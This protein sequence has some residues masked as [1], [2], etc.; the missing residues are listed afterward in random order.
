M[1]RNVF[2]RFGILTLFSYIFF[3][4]PSLAI[5]QK[6]TT[7]QPNPKIAP[8]KPK[9]KKS[10]KTIKFIAPTII[11]TEME[12]EHPPVEEILERGSPDVGMIAS[13]DEYGKGYQGNINGITYTDFVN[14]M[15]G[16]GGHGHT[17]P[18][19]VW[20]FGMVQ[21]SPDTRT[22][23]SWDGCGG[24]YYDDT[25]IYG[26]SHT[27]LSGTGVSD[28]GDVLFQPKVGNSTFNPLKYR[29][30][31]SH[32][33]EYARPG[34]YSNSLLDHNV[35]V[36]LTAHQRV[37]AHKYTFKKSTNQ[38][39]DS[40]FVII[41]LKHRDYLLGHQLDVETGGNVVKGYRRSK[42]WAN[43]QSV[44]F[45]SYF[46]QKILSVQYNENKS[47]AILY[48]GQLNDSTKR[49]LVLEAYVGISFTSLQGAELNLRTK[50]IGK[51]SNGVNYIKFPFHSIK[52]EVE[53]AWNKELGQINVVNAHS[54][55]GNKREDFRKF[56]TALYHCMIHP[57]LASDED[58]K[59]R[60]RDQQ[61]HQGTRPYYSVFS[62]WDTYRAL[63][64]L[65]TI[66]DRKR[67]SDFINTFL[68]Q[69]VQGGRLPVW[70]LGSCETDCMIGY[71]SVSVIADAL[72]KG[73]EN[74]DVDLALE[75]MI[76]SSN[77]KEDSYFMKVN[78]QGKLEKSM[79]KND[80]IDVKSESESVSKSLEYAYNDWCI[81][82][83]I[84]KYKL[85]QKIDLAKWNDVYNEMMRRSNR[86]QHY[87]DPKTKYMRP[88][89]N[90]EWIS[91]FEPRE[92]NNHFTEANSFQYSFYV[93]HQ[94]DLW[95]RYLGG[96]Q[97]LER[98]LDTLFGTT[99]KTTGREQSDIS[100]LIGQYA[101]GNE[102]SHHMVYLYNYCNQPL[103][104]QRLVRKIWRE[105]YKDSPDGLIGN[106]DCG[107]MSAWAVMSALGFYPVTP[108]NNE[109][110]VGMPF[111]DNI[112]MDV[113][114]ENGMSKKLTINTK[115]GLYATNLYGLKNENDTSKHSYSLFFNHEKLFK[116]DLSFNIIQDPTV[117]KFAQPSKSSN[118]QFSIPVPT[119]V[120]DRIFTSATHKITV[121][122]SDLSFYPG[123]K[124]PLK[125]S[126]DIK[127]SNIEGVV[128][129]ERMMHQ[130]EVWNLEISGNCE[131]KASVIGAVE[132]SSVAIFTKKENQY[133]V[134]SIKGAYNKQY[135]GGGDDALVNGIL[136]SEEWRSG[137]WQGY[138]NQ[139]FDA[140][141]DLGK[142]I[143]LNSIGAR[144]LQDTRA[145]I[146]MPTE[147]EYLVSKNGVDFTSVAKMGRFFPDTILETT[148]VPLNLEI[149]AQ[150]A[151]FIKVKAKNYGA[152][153]PWHQG[154]PFGGT[155][156]I[157]IDEIL[158][159]PPFIAE[160]KR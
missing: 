131:V 29:S 106:E 159:N 126:V 1:M 63:H 100:G 48:F 104:T 39:N 102:P 136:G 49:K 32:A 30:R 123:S 160:I 2:S 68:L 77:R 8:A 65:L 7:S 97:G 101:H 53:N 85:E 18:G 105:F 124:K 56:Y 150:E 142:P 143:T 78:H 103:K 37:G 64:P 50:V 70:E 148:V 74:I 73:I 4:M 83:V 98:Q 21:L 41:D 15:V 139:D 61:I 80:Y 5:A 82:K 108:G 69:Y 60:G 132:Y 45:Y 42:A 90:G 31:F 91:P 9:T 129:S 55:I 20:P 130:G 25:F 79:F 86:W 138:Q 14:P 12:S 3:S 118:A 75:A 47:V 54:S 6:K 135:S 87:L 76:H 11:P 16:T 151:R 113:R 128:H 13:D 107:Q 71:H 155:A 36:E 145:W 117:A 27:H 141:I 72:M 96:D 119:I 40:V 67:T 34:Y 44:F 81:A 125:F 111:F 35:N 99:S 134:V 19:A 146:L 137:D 122:P 28:Y 133:K 144:F 59:Y 57:S 153:P 38:T 154:F 147:V 33:S 22:D 89:V 149:K 24:Y 114:T 43:D 112:Q 88:K 51:N 62:L 109:Y 158:V 52:Y 121:V 92:V 17:F 116:G 152:L 110:A 26:F 157:F 84:E 156:F 46:S 115:P 23:A 95:K 58:N 10:P 66:I 93:P 120:G 140:V 127:Y 94:I